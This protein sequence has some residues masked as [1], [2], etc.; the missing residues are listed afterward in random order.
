MSNLLL[1]KFV[2]EI[3]CKN[4]LVQHQ[5]CHS[6]VRNFKCTVC[7]EGRFFKTK[8]YLNQHMVFHN[9]PKF[10]CSY[11]N[12]KSYRKCYILKH[13]KTHI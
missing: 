1:N 8:K 11:C 7:P 2:I 13:E 9:E 6:D 5:A 3:F 4:N 12:H 10:P